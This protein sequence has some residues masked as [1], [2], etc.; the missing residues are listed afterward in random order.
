[1]VHENPSFRTNSTCSSN[2]KKILDDSNERESVNDEEQ[3]EDP[4]ENGTVIPETYPGLTCNS[5]EPNN[6]QRLGS[7]QNK[8][9]VDSNTLFT[10]NRRLIIRDT[11]DFDSRSDFYLKNK[12]AS[13]ETPTE[14]V[15]LDLNDNLDE[16]EEVSSENMESPQQKAMLAAKSGQ[17][18]IARLM[19]SSQSSTPRDVKLKLQ[20][21]GLLDVTNSPLNSASGAKNDSSHNATEF[22]KKN[23][24]AKTAIAATKSTAKI[25][26]PASKAT[27]NLNLNANSPIKY[28]QRQFSPIVENASPIKF[29]ENQLDA[30][31]VI[32]TPSKI[33]YLTLLKTTP[34][35]KLNQNNNN[36][37]A[38]NSDNSLDYSY[39]FRELL[40][41][42]NNNKAKGSSNSLGLNSPGKWQQQKQLDFQKTSKTSNKSGLK[43]I[44]Y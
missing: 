14:N 27:K 31:G 26:K 8:E 20:E 4:I 24:P 21:H 13:H 3:L 40:N 25:D 19:K 39:E 7:G 29:N 44:T 6:S 30:N 28:I 12:N 16:I 17:D 43:T 38:N 35:S 36:N 10:K 9:N 18:P 23:P 5:N 15:S 34:N 33:V 37:N 11:L 42:N 41:N 1:M 32:T 22:V 2:L